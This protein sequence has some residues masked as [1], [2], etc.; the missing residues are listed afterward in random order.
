MG[1]VQDMLGV[2]PKKDPSA[3][4]AGEA[5][6]NILAGQSKVVLKAKRKKP[7]GM[8][9]EVFDLMRNEDGDI[10]A[11]SAAGE[12]KGGANGGG[13]GATGKGGAAQQAAANL[14]FKNKRTTAFQNK[15]SWERIH[16]SSRKDKSIKIYHWVKKEMRLND[17]PWT[18]FDV[19][20][21][22]LS[23][24]SFS[25]EEYKR[26][27]LLES[28]LWTR[29]DTE[30]L[31]AAAEE[32]NVRWQVIGDRIVLEKYHSIGDMQARYDYVVTML[33]KAAMLQMGGVAS[34]GASSGALP[35]MA[36]VP[37][38]APVLAPAP[39]GD[40]ESSTTATTAAAATGGTGMIGEE[41]EDCIHVAKKR[42]LQIES[43]FF[44]YVVQALLSTSST[45]A[46]HLLSNHLSH[47]FAVPMS[48]LSRCL[49]FT[50]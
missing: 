37:T 19:K 15:W 44:R 7:K 34:G 10:A 36:P 12:P 11:A 23:L 45:G 42:R 22:R 50:C 2:S 32:Y 27:L 14:G 47:L 33:Q 3:I 1:D 24:S 39:V 31:L 4:P 38:P 9:R 25:D 26:L 21:K 40:G 20:A 46:C 41:G 48:Q 13:G 28:P 30:A 6:L 29:R 35:A 8:S 17:Y 49:L 43:L 18:K 5:V 16:S